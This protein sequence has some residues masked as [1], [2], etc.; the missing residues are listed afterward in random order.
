MI[1]FK[2]HGALIRSRA[3]HSISVCV[4]FT[5]SLQSGLRRSRDCCPSPDR[6]NEVIIPILPSSTGALVYRSNITADELCRRSLAPSSP[7]LPAPS[8]ENKTVPR[9]VRP[10]P[11]E[12]RPAPQEDRPAPREDRPV[13]REDRPVPSSSKSRETVAL[14]GTQEVDQQPAPTRRENAF[15]ED[16]SSSCSIK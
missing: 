16:D 10:A 2:V 6:P 7:S 3:L 8:L 11:R 13:P 15:G 5:H 14:D 12:D 9:E 4:Y 1:T